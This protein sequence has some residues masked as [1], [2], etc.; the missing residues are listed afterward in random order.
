MK[1]CCGLICF[2]DLNEVYLFHPICTFGREDLWT[3]PKTIL[4]EDE[5]TLQCA[6]NAYVNMIPDVR[7]LLSNKNAY[8]DLGNIKAI[9][10]VYHIYAVKHSPA[11]SRNE[12]FDQFD[13]H[14]WFAFK[15]ARQHLISVFS[16]FIEMLEIKLKGNE[17]E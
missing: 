3:I 13:G 12:K 7:D 15:D 1:T 11:I 10:A 14:M 4:K 16:E 8:I 2:N 17:N 5:S 9:D 6:I